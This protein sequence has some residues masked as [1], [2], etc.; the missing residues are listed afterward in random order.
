MKFEQS[1]QKLAEITAQLEAGGLEL[2]EAVKL[3]GKGA[4]LADACKKELEQAKLAVSEYSAQK[5]PAQNGT[6]NS[7]SE[8]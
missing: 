5:Q 4:K 6:E 7:C 8:T 3:Y 1:M 2:E